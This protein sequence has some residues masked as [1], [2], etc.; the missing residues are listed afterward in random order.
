[1]K[2]NSPITERELQ[3]E[4]VL[5]WGAW[6]GY[7]L[8]KH[9]IFWLLSTLGL[10]LLLGLLALVS[11]RTR[12]H[13]WIDFE[14]RLDSYDLGTLGE[15]KPAEILAGFSAPGFNG[16]TVNPVC[17]PCDTGALGRYQIRVENLTPE[18]LSS[19]VV[20]PEVLR[21]INKAAQTGTI[22]KIRTLLQARAQHGREFVTTYRELKSDVFEWKLFRLSAIE[23]GN[24]VFQ[25]F[26][27]RTVEPAFLAVEQLLVEPVNLVQL[28]DPAEFPKLNPPVTDLI[29]KIPANLIVFGAEVRQSRFPLESYLVLK[30][31]GLVNLDV[32]SVRLRLNAQLQTL[33]RD[34]SLIQQSE[35][36]KTRQ[37]IQVVPASSR[38]ERE[39]STVFPVPFKFSNS[40]PL[41]QIPSLPWGSVFKGVIRYLLVSLLLGTGVTCLIGAR[42]LYANEDRDWA[43]AFRRFAWV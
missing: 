24:L 37:V 30:Q 28:S 25:P 7:F 19:P 32:E 10:F 14:I 23:G 5:S 3:I 22:N 27:A 18:A 33:A 34:A 9:K 16:F 39:F 13:Q 31:S 38:L 35:L 17:S 8:V 11:G 26:Q 29:T 15:I 1:M 20:G 12:L 40:A 4:D 21:E 43:E 2:P 42:S 6:G 36:I 41:G